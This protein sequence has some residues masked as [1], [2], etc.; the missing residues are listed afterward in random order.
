LCFCFD[1]YD[2]QIELIYQS[3]DNPVNNVGNE[4]NVNE[5]IDSVDNEGNANEPID[6]VGICPP[7]SDSQHLGSDEESPGI[8][9]YAG[10]DFG[11]NSY[12]MC[13][14][15]K[16]IPVF[17]EDLVDRILPLED[18]PE[19]M[20]YVSESRKR[21]S[22]CMKRNEVFK[23]KELSIRSIVCQQQICSKKAVQPTVMN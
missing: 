4:G 9:I 16:N 10:I 19:L 21:A 8:N 20:S 14:D 2:K 1:A 22:L 5:S 15:G 23:A 7:C 18:V 3:R 17:T 6:S 11:D 12:K 13:I